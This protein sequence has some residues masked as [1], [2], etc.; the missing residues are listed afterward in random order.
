MLDALP[1][2]AFE[3]YRERVIT[4]F[5]RSFPEKDIA[6]EEVA[7]RRYLEKLLPQGMQTPGQHFQRIVLDGRAVG[8]LWYAEQLEETPPR[9][10]LYDIEVDEQHRGKGIGSA[11]MHALEEEGRRLGAKQVML[12]VFFKNPGAIRLYE[13][14]GFEPTERGEAGMRM[15]KPL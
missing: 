3:A 9:V 15:A 14:L 2:D 6:Q 10:Y 11:A 1:D 12:A 8:T 5:A 7:A 4:R 13:R